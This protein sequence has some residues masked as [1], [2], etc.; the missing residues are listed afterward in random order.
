MVVKQ[1]YKKTINRFVLCFLSPGVLITYITSL[2]VFEM[3][4][5]NQTEAAVA[6]ST[7]LKESNEAIDNGTSRLNRIAKRDLEFWLPIAHK[8][9]L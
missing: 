5:H 4:H 2:N 1:K 8:D 3:F 6:S 9:M 7:D